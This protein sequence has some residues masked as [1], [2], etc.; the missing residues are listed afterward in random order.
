MKKIFLVSP[1]ALLPSTTWATQN[2][3]QKIIG[4][5]QCLADKNLI[6]E[7]GEKMQYKQNWR[8]TYQTDGS[9]QSTGSI[10]ITLLKSGL[11]LHYDF[12]DETKWKIDRDNL[13]LVV[14]RDIN[15]NHPAGQFATRE[16]V[17]RGQ[18]YDLI[19]GQSTRMMN[20]LGG[21]PVYRKIER[22]DER[23][24]ITADNEQ[25]D[26]PKIYCTREFKG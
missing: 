5:W 3:N 20:V 15:P 1:L 14:L 25:G 23:E 26:T 4:T 2:Y 19:I 21:A 16:S 10:D 11:H 7:D 8:I 9:A 17:K 18:R 22:L 6:I 13:E 12:Q 24:L